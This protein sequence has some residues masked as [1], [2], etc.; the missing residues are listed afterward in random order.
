MTSVSSDPVCPAPL[1]PA[2]PH[3]PSWSGRAS[4]FHRVP[5]PGLGTGDTAVDKTGLV[6]P[7]GSWQSCGGGGAPGDPRGA[8]PL[9]SE[10]LTP[11]FSARSPLTHIHRMGELELLWRMFASFRVPRHWLTHSLKH[12]ALFTHQT[13][14]DQKYDHTLCW[15]GWGNT[16]V[17][18]GV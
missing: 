2:P 12:N 4:S 15:R 14:R 5:S 6:P 10:Q 1:R 17:A 16:C 7:S 8:A 18:G 13:G 3:P 11:N 9:R